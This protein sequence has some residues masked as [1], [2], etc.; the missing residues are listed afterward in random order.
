MSGRYY[1]IDNRN[2]TIKK[3][4]NSEVRGT[5]A[6]IYLR[7]PNG[8]AAAKEA[9]EDKK[10]GI[11]SAGIIIASLIFYTIIIMVSNYI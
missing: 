7:T 6:I 10:R 5:A 4:F 3:N 9:Q 8:Y 2:K 1:V 11:I